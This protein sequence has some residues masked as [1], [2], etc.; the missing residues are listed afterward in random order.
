M[1]APSHTSLFARPLLRHQSASLQ[2]YTFQLE[3]TPTQ[4]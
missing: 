4:R 1:T 2:L 3:T